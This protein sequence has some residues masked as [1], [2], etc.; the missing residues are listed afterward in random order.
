VTIVFSE[1]LPGALANKTAGKADLIIGKD[2]VVRRQAKKAALGVVHLAALQRTRRKNDPDRVVH[3]AD[4]GSGSF[5]S[6]ISRDTASSW[7]RRTATKSISRPRICSSKAVFLNFTSR[8]HAQ[9]AAMGQPRSSTSNK[10]GTKS[11]T[12][13][14]SYAK[15]LLEGCGTVKK[16]D[17]RVIGE[18]DP[19]PFV[20]AF[21]N[22][23]LSSS[24]RDALANALLEVGRDQQLCKALE[25]KFGFVAPTS[26]DSGS[27][28]TAKKN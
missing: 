2:S 6:R 9:P 10:Q 28:V 8:R 24:M 20:A 26:S 7:A 4:E 21:A 1:T 25:T 16:G 5:R 18:T 19:V 11:A 27:T 15:P 22:A 23:T 14:S 12:I 3:R 13:I 17:L